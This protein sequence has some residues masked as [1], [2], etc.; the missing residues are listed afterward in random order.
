MTRFK[1]IQ[2][3]FHMYYIVALH[4]GHISSITIYEML[5]NWNFQ[6]FVNLAKTLN[7]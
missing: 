1:M 3:I 7:L 2:N 6:T 5:G 4:H